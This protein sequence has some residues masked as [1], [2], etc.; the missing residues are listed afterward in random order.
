MTSQQAQS[1]GS[2]TA[3]ART[4]DGA[5]SAA[6]QQL[7]HRI[8]SMLDEEA[9]LLA[10][11]P[12]EDFDRIIAR[13]NH[14]ALELARFSAQIGPFSPDAAARQKLHLA[15]A[16]LSENAVALQR[17]IDAV[18][19]IISMVTDVVNRAQSDGTYTYDAARRGPGA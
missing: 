17:N 9:Q 3:P 5:Q 15:Q 4:L 12:P 1:G 13:K 11:A 18:G 14:L 8:D 2:M 16:R 6:L 19:E 10:G 7:I